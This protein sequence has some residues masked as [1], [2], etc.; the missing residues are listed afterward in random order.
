M[1]EEMTNQVMGMGMVE[2][3]DVDADCY[4]QVKGHHKDLEK[5]DL[6]PRQSQGTSGKIMR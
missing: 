1:A 2:A 4:L 6:L 3:E 5:P